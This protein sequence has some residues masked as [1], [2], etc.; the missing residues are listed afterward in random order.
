MFMKRYNPKLEVVY[1]FLTYQIVNT[2]SKTQY[3]L[4]SLCRAFVL[5]ERGCLFSKQ[6]NLQ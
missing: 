6:I 1:V 5:I 2:T 3:A 4:L